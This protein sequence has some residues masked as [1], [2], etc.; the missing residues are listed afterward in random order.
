MHVLMQKWELVKVYIDSNNSPYNHDGV[1]LVIIWAWQDDVKHIRYSSWHGYVTWQAIPAHRSFATG[2]EHL[3][4]NHGHIPTMCHYMAM[5]W[6]FYLLSKWWTPIFGSLGDQWFFTWAYKKKWT[7]ASH[8][9]V[10]ND[11]QVLPPLSSI[12]AITILTLNYQSYF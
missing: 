2:F 12:K 8:F 11:C 6:V 5:S 4:F 9:E 3:M 7:L 10:G 1:Y